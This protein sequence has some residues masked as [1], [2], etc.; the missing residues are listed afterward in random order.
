MSFKVGGL[1]AYNQ[2]IRFARLVQVY[3]QA[4]D[5]GANL[6]DLV[7]ASILKGELPTSKI[8][9]VSAI[10][11]RDRGKYQSVCFNL[12]K[13]IAPDGFISEKLV[14]LSSLQLTAIY[15]GE[16]GTPIIFNPKQPTQL[17][18]LEMD[19]GELLVIYGSLGKEN[20]ES[21]RPELALRGID[22]LWDLL[23]DQ[24]IHE[25]SLLI[26]LFDLTKRTRG[27]VSQPT[28]GPLDPG[29]TFVAIE[30]RSPRFSQLQAEAW[31]SVIKAYQKATESPSSLTLFFE[32]KEVTEL[33]NFVT[34]FRIRRGKKFFL[35][36]EEPRSSL[37]NRLERF[38]NEIAASEDET[39]LR[40]LKGW[41]DEGKVFSFKEYGAHE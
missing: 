39:A 8:S 11:L 31:S 30:V 23:N 21:F 18:L 34:G 16:A 12:K 33:T 38:L 28:E 19:A 37:R 15:Y 27:L 4:L 35:E 6:G 7:P 5:V 2:N 36:S 3:S 22:Y 40:A 17:G 24:A 13:N 41:A 32:G 26:E 9:E 29:K 1:V 25:D 10:L 14:H 20:N